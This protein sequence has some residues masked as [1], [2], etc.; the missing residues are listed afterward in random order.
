MSTRFPESLLAV[1]AVPVRKGCDVRVIDQRV[2]SNTR[3]ALDE[4]IGPD[5]VVVGFTVI[6]GEQ[7]TY[8][9]ELTRYVKAKHP[10]VPVCWGGVHATLLPEQTAS[11]PLIDFVIAGEGDVVFHELFERLKDG[12]PVDDLKGLVFKSGSGEIVSNAGQRDVLID[13]D[14]LPD[15]PYDLLDLEKYGVFSKEGTKSATLSTSRGCPFRCK[16][17]SNPVINLGRWRGCSPQRVLEKV[18]V[19]YR[20]FGYNMIYFQDDYFPGNKERF[21]RILEGLARYERKLLW[22]TLGIR[23]DMLVKL[24]GQE[25]DLLYRSGCHSL[26]VGIES[27]NERVIEYVNKGETIQQMRAANR[28]LARHDIKVKYT[29]IVGFPGESRAEITDTVDFADELE[30]ANPHAYC[31]I[32]PFLPIVGTPFY[33]DAIEKGFQE[34]KTLDEWAGMNVN[35]WMREYR[36]WVSPRLVRTLEAVSFVSYFHNKNVA[37]KFGGSRLLRLAFRLYHPVARWRFSRRRFDHCA[38]I[39]AKDWLL[40]I[41]R[42]LFR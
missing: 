15:L 10:S 9:L 6:T 35:G 8:A 41:R 42:F 20:R 36:S 29:L 33:E 39:V 11:H 40:A 23:A 17:C 24:D 26:E 25:W 32:I 21:I 18:D 27:G 5:T 3:R 2:S 31:L 28:M 22:S 4:A 12:R 14:P 1:A 37:Y 13:L 30:R 7:I 16:F 34:P 19:L 38:E